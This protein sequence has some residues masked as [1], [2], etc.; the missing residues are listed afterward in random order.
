VSLPEV[1]D[2]ELQPP[3]RSAGSTRQRTFSVVIRI[4]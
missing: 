3:A 4:K 2:E 1:R